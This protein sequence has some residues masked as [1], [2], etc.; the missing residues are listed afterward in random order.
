MTFSGEKGGERSSGESVERAR[1]RARKAVDIERRK[2]VIEADFETPAIEEGSSVDAR[3]FA[4]PRK[5][6]GLRRGGFAAG[7]STFK[8]TGAVLEGPA[9]GSRSS[10]GKGSVVSKMT[11][12]QRRPPS[13]LLTM[14]GEKFARRPLTGMVYDAGEARVSPLSVKTVLCEISED[15]EYNSEGTVGLVGDAVKTSKSDGS[16]YGR[17][18]SGTVTCGDADESSGTVRRIEGAGCGLSTEHG[19]GGN[20]GE[21]GAGTSSNPREGEAVRGEEDVGKRPCESSVM[22]DRWRNELSE[23]VGKGGVN[24]DECSSASPTISVCGFPTGKSSEWGEE[25]TNCCV[26]PVKLSELG[27]LRDG[28]CDGRASC[29]SL[30]AAGEAARRD[31]TGE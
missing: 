9:K 2:L 7:I 26:S 6:R 11:S 24:R 19:L 13:L 28:G 12:S 31:G 17:E 8:S 30:G 10:S 14:I 5:A 22:C 29:L 4:I 23:G 27:D 25:G 16:R 21:C 3:C 15:E 1:V 18:M 20:R